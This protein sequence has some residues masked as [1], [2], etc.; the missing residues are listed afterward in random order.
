MRKPENLRKCLIMRTKNTNK[1]PIC[2][3]HSSCVLW[4]MMLTGTA[5]I[6]LA[7]TGDL[8]QANPGH[9]DTNNAVSIR[10]DLQL[11]TSSVHA[12]LA[13]YGLTVAAEAGHSGFAAIDLAEVQ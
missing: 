11:V 8:Q 5:R 13:R 2:R 9:F 12:L 6:A 10:R 1:L 7:A 4:I 3:T